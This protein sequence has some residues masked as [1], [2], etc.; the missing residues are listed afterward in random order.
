MGPPQIAIV[1][2]TPDSQAGALPQ[3]VDHAMLAPPDAAP[4]RESRSK[5]GRKSSRATR[6]DSPPSQQAL[7]IRQMPSQSQT[8]GPTPLMYMPSSSSPLATEVD[9]GESSPPPLPIPPPRG[10]EDSP[11]HGLETRME[12]IM[13]AGTHGDEGDEET[14]DSNLVSFPPPSSMPPTSR[15]HWQSGEVGNNVAVPQIW[16]TSPEMDARV[17]KPPAVP[18]VQPTGA[19]DRAALISNRGTTREIYGHPPVSSAAKGWHKASVEDDPESPWTTSAQAAA[20]SA[21]SSSRPATASRQPTTGYPYA[22]ASLKPA[23]HVTARPSPPSRAKDSPSHRVV[24]STSVPPSTSTMPPPAPTTYTPTSRAPLSAPPIQQSFSTQSSHQ[25]AQR[26]VSHSIAPRVTQRPAEPIQTAIKPSTGYSGSS[27]PH[28]STTVQPTVVPRLNGPVP[29]ATIASRG[30]SMSAY[31]GAQAHAPTRP[32]A[33]TSASTYAAASAHAVRPTVATANNVQQSVPAQQNTTGTVPSMMTATQSAAPQSTTSAQP[34]SATR[35]TGT[36]SASTYAASSAAHV[37]KAAVAPVNAPQAINSVPF[38]GALGLYGAASANGIG[39]QPTSTAETHRHQSG[40]YGALQQSS[41]QQP[42]A[43]PP[44]PSSSK[45]QT[46][47]HPLVDSTRPRDTTSAPRNISSSNGYPSTSRPSAPTSTPFQPIHQRAVSVPTTQPPATSQDPPSP[48]KFSQPIPVS[49]IST[50]PFPSKPSPPQPAR[51]PVSGHLSTPAPS[52]AHLTPPDQSMSHDSEM[53]N[54]PSSLAQSA[55]PPSAPVPVRQRQVSTDSKDSAKK[56]FLNFFK[57]KS[58][59]K[60][61]SAPAPP[62]RTSVDQQRPSVDAPTTSTS[63]RP[64]KEHKE[65]SH[66]QQPPAATSSAHPNK[67]A[68]SSQSRSKNKFPNPVSVPPMQ[69][70]ARERERKPS[71]TNVIPSLKFL[72]VNSSRKRTMSGLSLDVCDGNTAVCATHSLLSIVD[73]DSYSSFHR[74]TLWWSRLHNRPSVL[75]PSR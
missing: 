27:A 7:P 33:L 70:S 5:S 66:A 69:H 75:R 6:N 8:Q 59:S 25:P 61:N 73:A 50:Q 48:R 15:P 9:N 40:R 52:R 24:E 49:G 16:V 4:K 67:G 58:G 36:T 46:A 26:S 12:E 62:T 38:S 37:T 42:S 63:Q 54:T 71:L 31:T 68:S 20:T 39:A 28:P 13:P 64:A 53:L 29:S 14:W 21:P 60:E 18:T 17:S 51:I 45:T 47:E 55:M 34:P 32:P 3:H 65:R 1:G 44:V 2:A 35:P 11:S 41:S 23:D 57:T 30:T 74:P 10:L 22:S 56:K 72:N 43:T 19:T